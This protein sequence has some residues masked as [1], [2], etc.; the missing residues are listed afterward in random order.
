[1][2]RR[3]E[4]TIVVSRDLGALAPRKFRM[5]PGELD[6]GDIRVVVANTGAFVLKFLHEDVTGGLAVVIDVRFVRHAEEEDI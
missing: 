3:E 5:F 6:F 1:M 2:M 4:N